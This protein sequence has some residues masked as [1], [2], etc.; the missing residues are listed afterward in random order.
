MVEKIIS[1]CLENSE[2][3]KKMGETSLSEIKTYLKI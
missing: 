3:K 1:N 2:K